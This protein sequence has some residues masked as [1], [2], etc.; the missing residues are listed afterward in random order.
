MIVKLGT[1]DT[2]AGVGD[3][4]SFEV[5]VEIREFSGVLLS[6]TNTDHDTFR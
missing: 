4:M 5:Q 6:K 3:E 1:L 2:V